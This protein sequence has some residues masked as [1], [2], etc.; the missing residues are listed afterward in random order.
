M[1]LGRWVFRN[2]LF[3]FTESVFDDQ[4]DTNQNDKAQPD[5]LKKT[6]GRGKY[7]LWWSTLLNRLL[8]KE[9]TE[10]IA[11]DRLKADTLLSLNSTR[12]NC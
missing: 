2:V 6:L 10:S 12:N 7:S 9:G 3:N 5:S 4:M 11:S 1:H 8:V